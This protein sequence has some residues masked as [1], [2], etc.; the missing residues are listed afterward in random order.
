[1]LLKFNQCQFQF[2]ISSRIFYARWRCKVPPNRCRFLKSLFF[3]IFLIRILRISKYVY[4]QEDFNSGYDHTDDYNFHF[5]LCWYFRIFSAHRAL[6]YLLV[7]CFFFLSSIFSSIP[8]ILV[9]VPISLN[10]FLRNPN[11]LL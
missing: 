7:L 2:E 3:H 8:Q 9:P 6:L 10:W 4:V 1:M 11:G 5:S